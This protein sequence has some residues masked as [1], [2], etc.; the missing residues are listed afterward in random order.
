M[1]ITDFQ[2]AL[3]T[4]WNDPALSVWVWRAIGLFLLWRIAD[5][6]YVIHYELIQLRHKREIDS[7]FLNDQVVRIANRADP[8]PYWH[9]P[10]KR[11]DE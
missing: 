2:R 3:F 5:R 8:D 6:L 10:S 7:D 1:I 11:L 9:E 4:G